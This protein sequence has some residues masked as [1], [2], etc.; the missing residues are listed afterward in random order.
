MGATR[1]STLSTSIGI[2]SGDPGE[3]TSDVYSSQ[4]DVYMG[5]MEGEGAFAA[6]IYGSATAFGTDT[7]AEL[8]IDAQVSGSGLSIDFS[9][10]SA[11]Q[12]GDDSAYA[13]S[14]G[15]IYTYGAA[16]AYVGIS[17]QSTSSEIGPEGST[18]VST[19]HESI[20]AVNLGGESGSV[21]PVGTAATDLPSYDPMPYAPEP[22]EP[23]GCDS[24][25]PGGY[26][27]DGNLAIYEIDAVAFGE[28]SFVDVLLDAIVVEDAFSDITAVVVI[29]I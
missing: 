16:D 18:V 27:I 20:Y 28:N 19:Y 26:E 22:L 2:S 5:S 23:C 1:T 11:A 17:R 12:S 24:F 8:A 10:E 13:S 25:D 6:E 29:A 7:F 21:I 9:A 4:V 3:G 15:E 14:I